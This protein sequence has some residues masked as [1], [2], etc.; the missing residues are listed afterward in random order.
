MYKLNSTILI[1]FNF[2]NT[3]NAPL[4][5]H[6]VSTTCGCTVPS[7]TKKPIHIG[8]RGSIIVKFKISENSKVIH[9]TLFVKTN[10]REKETVLHI[11]GQASVERRVSASS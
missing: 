2:R 4:V 11:I 3:G 1:K 9:K 8:N 10:A 5:I 6:N 7:W